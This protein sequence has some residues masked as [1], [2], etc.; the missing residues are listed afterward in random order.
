MMVLLRTGVYNTLRAFRW[1]DILQ[2]RALRGHWICIIFI[3]V[4]PLSD[5]SSYAGWITVTLM[6]KTPVSKDIFHH[7]IKS[8][9]S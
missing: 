9:H 7:R 8:D 1:V 2:H 3:L 6:E 4:E 5:T